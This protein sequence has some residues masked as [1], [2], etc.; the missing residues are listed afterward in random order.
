MT[1]QPRLVGFNVSSPMTGTRYHSISKMVSLIYVC[2]D[3]PRKSGNRYHT[4]SSP[5]LMSGIPGVLIINCP[6]NRIGKFTSPSLTKDSSRNLSINLAT[7]LPANRLTLV[8]P[9]H[10]YH[11]LSPKSP[12]MSLIRNPIVHAPMRLRPP[13]RRHQLPTHHLPH[14]VDLRCPLQLM[15]TIRACIHLV[16]PNHM[17][18]VWSTF[19]KLSN[20]PSIV[21]YITWF[22]I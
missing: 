22:G 1:P 17:H 10:R 9:M 7:F 4:L 21:T 11:Q 12:T 3:T 13:Q 14:L 20:W 15:M 8:L 5:V 16:P 2:S 6:H 19:T 18:L